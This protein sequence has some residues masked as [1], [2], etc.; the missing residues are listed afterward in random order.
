MICKHCLLLS[1]ST[2]FLSKGLQDIQHWLVPNLDETG[3]GLGVGL[4]TPPCKTV[5]ATEMNDLMYGHV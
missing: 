3:G 1:V 5:N 2:F 4:A